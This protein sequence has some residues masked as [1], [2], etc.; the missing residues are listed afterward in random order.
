MTRNST[1]TQRFWF[2]Q[3]RNLEL[4]PHKKDYESKEDSETHR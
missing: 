4:N 2:R 3:T 1:P